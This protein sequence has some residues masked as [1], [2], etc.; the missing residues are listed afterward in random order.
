[1]KTSLVNA[2][3]QYE[4]EK[5]ASQY[6]L[7]HY[8]KDEEILPFAF[9]PKEALSFPVRCVSECL[10][11]DRL[12]PNATALEVGCAVGRASFELSRHFQKVV[13]VDSSQ[14]FIALAKSIQSGEK[15]QYFSRGEGSQ[16]LSHMVTLPA[17]VHAE[18]VQ[19]VCSDIL[20]FH[21]EGEKFDLLLAANLLCRLSDPASFLKLLPGWVAPAGQLILISPYSWCLE[22]TPKELWP[23]HHGQSNLQ[24]IAS[25]LQPHF[26][27]QRTFEMPFLL[28]EHYRKYQWGVSQA[29]LWLRTA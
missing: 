18:R 3:S 10:E 16:N 17:D 9:G 6:L 22:Y 8:G 1:M 28:Q 19:F 5:M 4:T 25:R 23:S 27:L 24:F 20:C 29:T 15:V 7:F 11:V 26:T 13:A 14:Q 2:S 21:P 12:P